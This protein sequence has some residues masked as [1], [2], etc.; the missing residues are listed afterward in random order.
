MKIVVVGAGAT[1]AV[2]G[3]YLAMAGEEV[4]FLDP[5]T[6]HMQACQ[7]NGLLIQEAGFVSGS[8]VREHR[9]KVHAT[10]EASQVGIADLIL[11]MPKGTYTRAAMKNAI[12]VSDENTILLT[13]QNGL[14]N[15]EIITES[16]DARRVAYGITSISSG[17]PAPGVVTPRIPP[18]H[19]IWIGSDYPQLESVLR[20]IAADYCTLGLEAAYDANIKVRV[21]EKFA[22]NCGVNATTAILRLTARNAAQFQD[23]VDIRV[24]VIREI[25]ALAAKKGIRLNPDTIFMAGFKAMPVECSNSPDTYASMAQDA[26][27]RRPTE[28][29]NLNGYAAAE[30]RRM[31]V[32]A[33]Y[34][35]C[36]AKLMH[37]IEQAYS[38]QF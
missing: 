29:M 27:E 24:E 8:E 21:W 36:I 20:H 11:F 22:L 15:M 12:A 30:A 18:H 16:F 9:V 23:Y 38:L 4:W 7:E 26:K 37:T 17:L 14:G 1:G 28:I 3:G 10:T 5:N 25:E 19:Q 31:G 33:P 13:L 32:P 2:M 35:E 6:A 34:N